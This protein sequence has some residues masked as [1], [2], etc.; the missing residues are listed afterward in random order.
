MFTGHQ[1]T[2]YRVPV[3]TAEAEAIPHN[4]S[5]SSVPGVSPSIRGLSSDDLLTTKM[6]RGTHEPETH[7]ANSI[8]CYW[9][10][11]EMPMQ[12]RLCRGCD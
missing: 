3:L 4:F 11:A 5:P 7:D 8:S 6:T 12:V 9:P 1:R 2:G 10:D